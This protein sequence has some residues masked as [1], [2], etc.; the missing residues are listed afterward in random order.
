M[1]IEPWLLASL[2]GALGLVFGSFIA[3]LAIRWPQGRSALHGRS[4]CDRC[5]KGLGARELVPILSFVLQRGR[6][7]GCGTA[8][9]PSHLLT[10]LAGLAIGV[11]A[12]LATASTLAA[13]AGAIFGWLLLMLAAMDLAAFWLPNALTGAL[14]ATGLAVGLL[15][16]APGM[17][18]RL[19]G[20]IGGY[21]ALAAVAAGYRVIRGRQGLGGGD[22]KLFGAIGC[23]LGWQALPLVQLAAALIGIAAVLGFMM[24]GRKVTATDRLPFGVMLAT[25][26]FAV[27]IGQA[28]TPQPAPEDIVVITQFA[29]EPR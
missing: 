21:A 27:W 17:E 16:M 5:G 19:I 13:V 29:T 15:G 7:R 26:A 11:A 10:E 3:T 22:P 6:C 24:G 4:Q 12:A 14:A 28:L 25:A 8:I 9:P 1:T 20:G 18:A 23:W 2:L